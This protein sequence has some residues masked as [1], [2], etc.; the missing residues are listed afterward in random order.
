[1]LKNIKNFNIYLFL[2][3]VINILKTNQLYNLIKKISYII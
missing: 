3:I 1:M 2:F